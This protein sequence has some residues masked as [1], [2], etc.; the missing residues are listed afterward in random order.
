MLR[1]RLR[2]VL[3]VIP[4]NYLRLCRVAPAPHIHRQHQHNG[5]IGTT[6]EDNQYVRDRGSWQLPSANPSSKL[7]GAGWSLGEKGND[8]SS[9][10]PYQ[11]KSIIFPQQKVFEQLEEDGEDTAI[12]AAGETS[13]R[14]RQIRSILQSKI[15]PNNG[16][17]DH[18]ISP[19]TVA[20]ET[21][22]TAGTVEAKESPRKA[23]TERRKL[24][25][26][27]TTTRRKATRT[28]GWARSWSLRI[29]RVKRRS[30]PSSEWNTRLHRR[31]YLEAA[32]PFNIHKQQEQGDLGKR[33]WHLALCR[34]ILLLKGGCGGRV[35]TEKIW[36]FAAD[37]LGLPRDSISLPRQLRAQVDQMVEP[38]V[39]EIRHCQLRLL[40]KVVDRPE[41]AIQVMNSPSFLHHNIFVRE[42]LSL[43]AARLFHRPQEHMAKASGDV[44]RAFSK[45][46]T[47]W[48]ERNPT[49]EVSQMLIYSLVRHCNNK[50]VTKMYT[51][52]SG[53]NAALYHE[54]KMKFLS[55]F[56]K[57]GLIKPALHLLD[58]LTP[59]ELHMDRMQSCFAELLRTSANIDNIYAFQSNL[60]TKLLEKGVKPNLRLHN[61]AILNAI[62][63]GDFETGWSIFHLMRENEVHPDHQTFNMLLARPDSFAEIDV[64][65]EEARSSGLDPKEPIL[66][67]AALVARYRCLQREAHLQFARDESPLEVILPY[68][69]QSFSTQPLEDL[70][71]LLCS[72]HELSKIADRQN[73]TIEALGL[74]IRLYLCGNPDMS[75]VER[76]Y[77]TYQRLV[78]ERNP[79]IY[80]LAWTTGVSDAFILKF[81]FSWANLPHCLEVFR[82]IESPPP[83]IAGSPDV[84]STQYI[85]YANLKSA[86]TT[87]RNQRI[88]PP[89]LWTWTV[90]IRSMLRHGRADA[91]EK[92]LEAMRSQTKFKPDQALW[93]D[94]ISG[95]AK[96]RN[97]Q[98]VLLT[99]LEM[100]G[101]GLWGD[102]NTIKAVGKLDQSERAKIL[103][104]L[105]A[106]RRAHQAL[107]DKVTGDDSDGWAYGNP[108]IKG[109]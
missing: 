19:T 45:F 98:R 70:G 32:V 18:L 12:P 102:D 100:E 109:L 48:N 49:S 51:M 95:Y 13:E 29:V 3:S 6:T 63:A 59:K 71:I 53:T 20:A 24:T 81:G 77:Q 44:Y 31:P 97:S 7:S 80:P 88:A 82:D 79:T 30:A 94:L 78:Q 69:Q 75:D 90:L 47:L 23:Y 56:A 101:D 99:I 85:Q 74:M 25:E 38:D 16:P 9:S 84:S 104:A 66:A 62:Q 60:L 57:D 65:L 17:D 103:K 1:C 5:P 11:S 93:N 14:L 92:L 96:L 40:H 68:Y 72:S 22:G 42:C 86:A 10:R 64:V 54:T 4:Q 28:K 15:T 105:D 39:E 61:V 33:F 87:A 83:P 26:R 76:V 67:T 50:A 8:A 73:P 46:H 106:G 2:Q 52:L 89:S 34:T 41:S 36:G 107:E 21:A 58:H 37:T 27:A 108:S 35:T 91:A 43:S 55:R